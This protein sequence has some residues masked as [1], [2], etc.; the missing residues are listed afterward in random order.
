MD[1]KSLPLMPMG[2]L[3]N[4]VEAGGFKLEYHFDD[5]VFIDNTSLLFRFDMEKT[6]MVYLHF[7]VD[8]TNEARER[9]SIFFTDQSVKEGLELSVSSLFQFEQ[10]EGKEEISITFK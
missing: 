10:T 2:K 9:L 4:M 1:K 7:N 5:L 8:C 3:L 6:N